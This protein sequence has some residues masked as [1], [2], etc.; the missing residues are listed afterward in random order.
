MKREIKFR[1][2]RVDGGGWVYG[3]YIESSSEHHLGKRSLIVCG[4][5]SAT[6]A[7]KDFIEVIPET[8]GQFTGLKDKNGV[9]IYEG[10]IL[11]VKTGIDGCEHRPIRKKVVFWHSLYTKFTTTS[12]YNYKNAHNYGNNISA[13]HISSD[14]EIIGDIHENKELLNK[15]I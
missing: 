5:R 13:F 4:D 10:D 1:G 3:F 12:S 6:Y 8:V 15:V 9:D 2:L 7:G 11:N 14:N